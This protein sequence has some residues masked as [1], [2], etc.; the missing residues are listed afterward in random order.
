M[1]F[2]R[3]LVALL[4]LNGRVASEL[5][6]YLAVPFVVGLLALVLAPLPV[7]PAASVQ[8]PSNPLQFVP[9]LQM[10]LAF[11]GVLFAT[12]WVRAAFGNVGLVAS[13]AFLGL[14]DVDALT[15]SMAQAEHLGTSAAVAARAIAVG[16]AANAWIKLLIVMV[17]GTR[18]YTRV[19]AIWLGIIAVVATL[20]IF[21]R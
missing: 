2:P 3:I 6:L 5:L 15:V 1:L 8:T 16:V 17:L 21:V 19:A 14:T 11:Q 20:V 9:A 12:T 13:G 7:E 4:F 10:A 18:D